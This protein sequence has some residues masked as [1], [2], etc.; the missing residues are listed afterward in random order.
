[1]QLRALMPTTACSARLNSTQLDPIFPSEAA[2]EGLRGSLHDAWAGLKHDPLKVRKAQLLTRSSIV[3]KSWWLVTAWARSSGA[4]SVC[5]EQE[6]CWLGPMVTCCRL[7]P[8]RSRTPSQTIASTAGSI[9]RCCHSPR[10]HM[11]LSL[12]SSSGF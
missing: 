9:C 5:R 3:Y 12:K 4:V 2:W 7:Q 1:M 10:H 11:D 8:W 6:S